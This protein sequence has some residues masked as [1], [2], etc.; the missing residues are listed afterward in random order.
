MSSLVDYAHTYSMKVFEAAEADPTVPSSQYQ[1]LKELVSALGLDGS[2]P[3]EVVSAEEVLDSG[4][5]PHLIVIDDEPTLLEVLRSRLIEWGYP[6]EYIHEFTLSSDAL[7]FAS[8][9][10]VGIAFIDIKL[11]GGIIQDPVYTSGMEVLKAIKRESPDAL[12]VLASGFGTYEM[13]RRGI[14]DLG[15]SFYLS[16]P[17]RLADVVRIVCWGVDRIRERPA[18]PAGRMSAGGDAEHVLIVDDDPVLSES[19]SLGLESFGYRTTRVSR[20]EDA[21]AAVRSTRFDA[22]LL[23]LMM[24]GISGL[25]V[26][27]WLQRERRHVDVF[28]L[29]A[30]S[31]DLT[32][33]QVMEL[34]AKGYFLKPCDIS[35]ITRTLEFHFARRLGAV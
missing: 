35:L 34:G 28:V 23:D 24:P 5:I 3:R 2:T 30:V 7:H 26:M 12:A 22:I 13:A 31:D 15:A 1:D 33:R 9:N 29:S 32:A 27:R 20:G 16:K 4:N 14:L 11:D 25:D 6:P 21:F 10:P 18:L 17:F 19:V 8:N